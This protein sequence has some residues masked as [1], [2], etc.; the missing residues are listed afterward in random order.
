MATFDGSDSS[1]PIRFD[2]FDVADLISGGVLD[3]STINQAVG[4][5]SDFTLFSGS[6]FN[7]DGVLLDKGTI[8]RIDTVAGNAHQY[9]FDGLAM[10]VTQFRGF[11]GTDNSE[12]FL[13][14]A[15]AGGD[16]VTGSQLG[17]YLQG[18]AG[19]DL[20][21]GD[22]NAGGGNDTLDGG[23]G[24]DTMDGSDGN[25]LYIIDNAK[26][27]VLGDLGGIDSVQSAVSYTL[28]SGIEHLFL[29]GT[30]ALNGTGNDLANQIVGTSGANKLLGLDA[31][32]YLEGAAGNDTLDG[33]AGDDTMLGGAGSDVYF[34]DSNSDQAIEALS[35]SAGGADIVFS[36]AAA[37]TLG[38]NIE[39]LT[40]MGPATAGTGNE[41]ANVI[42]GD[43]A[44]DSLAGMAA[45]DTLVGGTGN[46]QL[47]GG[48]GADS[49]SGGAGSDVYFV[50]DAGDKVTEAMAGAAGGQDAVEYS[51]TVGYVLGNNLEELEMTAA[52][53]AVFGTGNSLA[54]SIIGNASANVI[55]GKAGADTMVGG[56]GDDVYIVDNTKD[57]IREDLSV[58]NDTVNSSVNFNLTADS[59]TVFGD[60]ENLVL[61]GAALVGTGNTLD[62][63]IIGD[64]GK[65]LLTGLEGN[66]TLD[67]GAGTDTLV[68]GIGNDLY[69]V[70]NAKDVISELGSD[71]GDTV[72]SST[73]S[74]D[75]TLPAY[76]GIENIELQG[77]LALHAAGNDGVNSITGNDGA[78]LLSGHGG[79]DVLVGGAGN[80][81]LDGGGGVDVMTGGAGDDTYLVDSFL[82]GSPAL[83]D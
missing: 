49:M 38:P 56:D 51:G 14:A 58:G 79:N 9:A 6:G 78:N 53:G 44:G 37:F 17:D 13:A 21:I 20:L 47:D 67:G 7:N 69:V 18:F 26:D 52:I 62:N 16:T 75:L 42:T 22:K 25:D 64:A 33:G 66:D 83:S 76:A 54:N 50:D 31:N 68:G 70:D 45:N 72:R 39:K 46:D 27:S 48:T 74:L 32:D 81:T 3:H 71:S 1:S 30:G 41:L 29:T 59:I 2:L 65:N 35:G 61:V 63:Q 36:S 19:N 43:N 4:T 8:N 23:V 73:I 5:S 77:K 80:D 55:D 82:L 15:F 34:V 28:G 12:G 60:I 57:V 24:A 11:T 10:A 40:L